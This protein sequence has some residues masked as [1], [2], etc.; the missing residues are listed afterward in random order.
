MTITNSAAG[1]CRCS[2]NG[3]YIGKPQAESRNQD[4]MNNFA[5][6]LSLALSGQ[7]Q[8]Y[9]VSGVLSPLTTY[10]AASS[11]YPLSWGAAYG[12]SLKNSLMM[13][14]ISGNMQSNP[15]M[16]AGLLRY[17]ALSGYSGRS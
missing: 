5:D 4:Y 15:F 17:S 13:S 7:M 1:V 6:W 11:G 2:A 12:S 8:G 9:P 14:A 16:L 10:S 3:M